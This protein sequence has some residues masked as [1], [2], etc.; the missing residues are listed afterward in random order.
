MELPLWINILI[1]KVIAFSY[2]ILSAHSILKRGSNKAFILFSVAAIA[3]IK[4]GDFFVPFSMNPDEEQWIICANSFSESPKDWLQYYLYTD[5][6]RIFSF[7]PISVLSLFSGHATYIHARI[8]AMLLFALTLVFNFKLIRHLFSSEIAKIATALALLLFSLSNHRDLINYNSEIPVIFLISAIG[9]IYFTQINQPKSPNQTRWLILSGFCIGAIPFAKEQAILLAAWCGIFIFVDLFIQ[10]K[11]KEIGILTTASI[12]LPAVILG[13]YIRIYQTETL[14]Q[15][16]GGGMSYASS[17]ANAHPQTSSGLH[18]L[19]FR[20]GLPILSNRDFS[21]PLLI[22][23]LSMFLGLRKLSAHRNTAFT[24]P[25]VF[26]S[27]LFALSVVTILI[28]KSPIHHYYIFLFASLPFFYAAFI[29]NLPQRFIRSISA[30]H[31]FVALALVSSYAQFSDNWIHER[32]FYTNSQKL[33]SMSGEFE[34]ENQVLGIARQHQALSKG[35]ACWGFGNKYYLMAPFKRSTAF[36]YSYF[37]LIHFNPNNQRII[38][39][40]LLDLE[41]FKPYS[42]IDL[43]NDKKYWK[44]SEKEQ[45]IAYNSESLHRYL[46]AHYKVVHTSPTF[47]YYIRTQ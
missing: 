8:A 3:L 11:Y 38:N 5:Y 28:I 19:Y 42:F 34:K 17:H 47:D 43:K 29:Q 44:V 31:V 45:E 2:L 22:M 21:I 6:S 23:A 39:K 20:Y 40:Y 41:H 37:A 9:W 13:A 4:F 16:I 1:V 7:L 18:F 30:L 32:V 26:Y 36:L 14:L 27:I 35:A 15:M 12:A 10:K 46:S 33:A 25:F 24:K